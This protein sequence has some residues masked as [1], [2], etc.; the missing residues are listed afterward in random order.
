MCEES[1][2]LTLKLREMQDELDALAKEH[3]ECPMHIRV[4]QTMYEE[5]VKERDDAR[6]REAGALALCG[7]MRAWATK[8][9]QAFEDA[10]TGHMRGDWAVTDIESAAKQILAQPIPTGPLARAPRLM[11]HP[12]ERA[13]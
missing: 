3:F 6:E 12:L 10:R 11:Q 9:L 5:T 13:P 8:A 1:V 4:L 7:E 2:A